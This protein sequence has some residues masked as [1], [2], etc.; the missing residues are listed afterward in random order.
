MSTLPPSPV[1]SYPFRQVRS[2]GTQ[3][4]GP[5]L[6]RYQNAGQMRAWPMCPPRPH[7]RLPARRVSHKHHAATATGRHRDIGLN[8]M[9]DTPSSWPHRRWGSAHDWS[10]LLLMYPFSPCTWTGI[11]T[12]LESSSAAR[13]QLKWMGKPSLTSIPTVSVYGRPTTLV[14]EPT[15]FCTK[16]PASP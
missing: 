3:P 4:S 7:P 9:A 12:Q 5:L 14:Y 1:Q 6:H 11:N 15:I 8:K 16:H 10:F 13:T 2:L